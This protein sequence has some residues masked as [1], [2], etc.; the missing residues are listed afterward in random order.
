[1]K[2]TGVL[3]ED[4]ILNELADNRATERLLAVLGRL[5][6]RMRSRVGASPDIGVA[7]PAGFSAADAGGVSAA[8]ASPVAD[9]AELEALRLEN[10]LLNARCDEARARLDVL[11]ERLPAL[12]AEPDTGG[13]PEPRAG[14]G[15]A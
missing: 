15:T 10:R 6:E 2:G 4:V 9:A 1:M 8:H 11:L 13:S 14:E 5:E 3:S 7:L 12:F